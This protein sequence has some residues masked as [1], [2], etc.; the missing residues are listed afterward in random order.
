MEPMLDVS[1]LSFDYLSAL[2]C[3]PVIDNISFQVPSC[4]PIYSIIISALQVK[5]IYRG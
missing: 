1:N 5:Y 2:S 3:L 4:E